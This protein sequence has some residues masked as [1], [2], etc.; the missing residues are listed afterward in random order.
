MNRYLIPGTILLILWMAPPASAQSVA[1]T[2]PP[3]VLTVTA[4]QASYHARE[5]LV[6]KALP[7]DAVGT[8]SNISGS[9]SLN[10]DGGVA[11]D[12]STITVDLTSLASDEFMRD[13]FIK[14]NTLQI[15]QFPAAIFVPNQVQGL[16]SLPISGQATFQL[17]G[18]LTIHGV[19]QPATWQVS[20]TFDSGTVSGTATT[21]IQLTDFGMTPPRVGPVLSIDN[22]V[23][24]Q[25]NFLA[26]SQT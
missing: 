4:G 17:L 23:T 19:T 3:T 25:L 10:P 8:T 5:Q 15:S 16:S 22:V 11:A 1:P 12:Q 2:P 7:T 13:N 24:L 9:V 18:N 20:A 21:P 26:T 6:G 14:R